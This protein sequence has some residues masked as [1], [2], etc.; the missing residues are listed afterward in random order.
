MAEDYSEEL[1][2]PTPSIRPAGYETESNRDLIQIIHLFTED[3]DL[4]RVFVKRKQQLRYA[5][6]HP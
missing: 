1:L 5:S 2:H 6:F 3:S 4:E